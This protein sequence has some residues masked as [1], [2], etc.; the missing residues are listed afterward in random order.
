MFRL[1]LTRLLLKLLNIPDIGKINEKKIDIFFWTV[2][3]QQGFQDYITKRDRE[4][5]VRMGRGVTQEEY[6]GLLHQRIELGLW[7]SQAKTSY[8]RIEKSRKEK[9]ES[10]RRI[11]IKQPQSKPKDKTEQKVNENTDNK[12]S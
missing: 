4:I 2:R 12:Q 3:P 8:A 1:F 11:E 7:L 10:L 9:M 5:M 6:L